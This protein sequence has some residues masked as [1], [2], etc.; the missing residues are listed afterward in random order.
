M[1]SQIFELGQ[2]NLYCYCNLLVVALSHAKWQFPQLTRKED[3]MIMQGGPAQETSPPLVQFPCACYT[4]Y[5]VLYCCSVDWEP[6]TLDIKKEV[7]SGL[8]HL[9]CISILP[10]DNHHFHSYSNRNS[11]WKALPSKLTKS[12]NCSNWGFSSKWGAFARKDDL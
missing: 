11:S 6:R 7:L 1:K 12:I 3:N 10:L 8:T 4:G 5:G 9:H 2:R